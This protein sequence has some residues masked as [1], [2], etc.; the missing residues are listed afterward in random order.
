[1]TINSTNTK[2][3]AVEIRKELQANGTTI[4]YIV[5]NEQKIGMLGTTSE[6]DRQNAMKAIQTA[7]DA[8]DGNIYEMMQKLSII[9]TIEEK[10]I[11]PDEMVDVNDEQ[12]ILSYE[13][14]KAYDINGE[15]IANCDDLP[16]MPDEAIKAV[17]IARVEALNRSNNYWGD[18]YI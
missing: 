14:K 16:D 5:V 6:K 2:K 12:I 15:E 1:M 13:Q 7:L 17:L 4:E 9:A 3:N 18:E 11:S 10:E 8:S